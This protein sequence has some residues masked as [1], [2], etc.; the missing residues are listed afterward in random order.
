[1]VCFNTYLGVIGI[2]K[3]AIGYSIP[4]LISLDFIFSIIR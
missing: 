3:I 2:K 1:M 4:S